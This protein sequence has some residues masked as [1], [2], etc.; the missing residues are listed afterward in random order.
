MAHSRF[1]ASLMAAPFAA[2]VLCAPQL[3]HAGGNLLLG[4]DG[5]AATCSTDWQAVTTVPGW[6]V[7]SGS[8]AVDCYSIASFDTPNPAAAGKAFIAAGPYGDSAL[9]QIVNVSSSAAA[10]DTGAVRFNLSGWLGGW[11]EYAGQAV[12][13]AQF[14]DKTGAAIGTPATLS[15]VTAAARGNMSRFLARSSTGAVP[16]GTRSIQ[17][18]LQFTGTSGTYNDAYADNLS[19]TL[20]TKLATPTLSPPAAHVPQFDHMFLVMMENTNYDQVIGD[21][22]N[23]PFI[24]SLAASGTLLANY[25]GVYHPSDENYLA[26]AG[27]NTFVKGAI[28]YPNIAVTAPSIA[29]SLEAAGKT[30]RAYEQGMGVPCNTTSAYD[31]YYEPDDAPFFNFANIQSN[32]RRCQDHLVDTKQLPVD[33]RFAATTPNFA[34]IAAD[35]YFDGEASGNGSPHSLRAQ[36]SWLRHTL[37][38]VLNSPAW[39]QQKSLL[40]LTWDESH[41]YANNHIATI[42]LGSQGLVNAGVISN[43]PYNHYSTGRTIETALGLAP[44]TEND[45]FAQTINDAFTSGGTNSPSLSISASSVARGTNLVATFFTPAVTVSTTDWIG[46]YHVG[47]TPGQ[48]ASTEWQYVPN[49]SGSVTFTTSGLTPGQ[50]DIYY[51]Y[52]D[53]YTVLAGPVNFTV[54]Q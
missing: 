35:D 23:A 22:I 24:N 38:P 13:T 39:K 48:I 7:V 47:Q 15:G 1:R 40:I 6:T 53:G 36:D 16:A 42:L 45:G 5:E 54:T 19:L 11:A 33:L 2:A 34:W 49:A 9:Q 10:I 4:G 37:T 51:F 21:K 46:I 30:W 18:L 8:P 41:T 52:N 25:S 12:V 28:Y 27:G 43:Q 3:A 44:L 29:D 20:S 31:P 26:I 17:V 32:Q 50:Y 14:R